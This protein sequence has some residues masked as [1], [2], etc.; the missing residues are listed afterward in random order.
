MAESDFEVV[1][2][3]VP[4]QKEAQYELAES[5][6]EEEG[7]PRLRL[8][9]VKKNNGGQTHVLAS[10]QATW[11]AMEREAGEP[12]APAGEIAWTMFGR[13]TQE[14]WFKYMR[15]EYALDVLVDYSVE[16]DDQEHLVVNPQWR[17]LDRQVTSARAHLER[18]QAKY[19]QLKILRGLRWP[20]ASR[21]LARV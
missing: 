1:T 20:N 7:W 17:E 10:S 16:L 4:G 5:I 11:T 9:A 2:F 13:W 8:I 6:F 14:N 15:A 3:S 12:D 18:A 19:A 21:K